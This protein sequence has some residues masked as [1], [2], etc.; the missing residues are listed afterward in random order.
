MKIRIKQS[1]QNVSKLNIT[2]KHTQ[3]Q[4]R[5]A[6][7]RHQNTTSD[8]KLKQEDLAVASIVRDDPSTLPGDDP[9]SLARMHRD[10]NVR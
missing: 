2:R 8:E 9:A 7:W 5:R 1:D 3:L 10:R 6:L 4:Q